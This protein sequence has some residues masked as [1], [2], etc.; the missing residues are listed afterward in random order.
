MKTLLILILSVAL[1]AVAVFTRPSQTDFQRY[2]RQQGASGGL[3]LSGVLKEIEMDNY[4]KSVTF[5]DHFLYVT[6]E[7]NGQRQYTGMFSHWFKA[8]TA[9]A[10]AT[11]QPG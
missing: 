10:P 8:K 7:K 6:V 5:K 4:L 3:S 2:I 11:A 1:A 9:N